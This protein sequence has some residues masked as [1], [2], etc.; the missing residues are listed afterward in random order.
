[1]PW[2]EY[3]G[4]TPGGTAIVGR[5]EAVDRQQAV[6]DLAGMQVD[7]RELAE[8]KAPSE[9]SAGLTEDDLIFFNEQVA[10][11]AQAGIAL[12]EG[13]VQLARDISSRSLRQWVQ[14]LVDD[15]RRGIPIDQA[16]AARERGLPILYSRVIRAG[17]DSGQLAATLL[18]LNHH[19]RLIGTTRRILWELTTY[20]L[21]VAVLA[22]TIISG[23]FL[24]VVPHFGD[25]IQD[26]DTELPYLTVLVIGIAQDYPMIMLVGAVTLAA[27][28]TIWNLLKFGWRGRRI[29]EKIVFM[30]PV[31]GRVHLMS[32]IARFLRSVATSV[33]SGITLPQALRLGAG[34]TGSPSLIGDADYL[35][36]EVEQGQSIFVANQSARII[37][38]LF[39]YCVQVA[40]GREELPSAIGKLARSYE[41][42][43]VHAQSMMQAILGPMLIIILGSIIL[44]VI[45]GL[46]LPLVTLLNALTG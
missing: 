44:F 42:R 37:P 30:I 13:L 14:A 20:P 32:L 46:F 6:D 24:F 2:Y 1:M 38:P 15:L 7:V 18:N 45:V 34:A 40:V 43:A 25:I 27:I 11:L 19:L 17:I 29:R 4:L 9:K 33:T 8:A 12:D 10:S 23:V 28:I 36:K 16:I 22:L 41:N 39:G 21:I 31:I 35:A 5:L 3:E 26:F